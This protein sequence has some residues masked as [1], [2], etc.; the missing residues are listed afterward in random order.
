MQTSSG[1]NKPDTLLTLA[2]ILVVFVAALAVRM[3]QL[4]N[5]PI[6]DELYHLLSAQSW[7][8]DGSFAIADGEYRRAKAFTVLVG[9][10]GAGSNWSVNAIRIL[11]IAIGALL[12]VAVYRWTQLNV[13]WREALVASAFLALLPTAIFLSQHIRFYGL[14]ALLFFMVAWCGWTLLFNGN[15]RSRLFA[16][17]ALLPLVALALHLQVT[18]LVGIAGLI[19]WA[20]L[21]RGD[22]LLRLVPGMRARVAAG[23]ILVAAF[24]LLATFGQD[25]LQ[26]LLETYQESALWNSS[27]NALYY[28]NAYRTDFGVLWALTPVAMIVAFI[29]RPKP[30]LF[31][32]CVFTVAFIF[33]S[34]GGM[35]S[36]RFMF[37]AL[38]FLLIIWSIAAVALAGQLR[39]VVATALSACGFMNG[40][41]RLTSVLPAVAVAGAVGF[42]LITVPVVETSARMVLGVRT[43]PPQYWDRY[44]SNWQAVAPELRALADDAGVLVATQPLHALWY[45]GEI[46][47]AMNATSLA[48][49][50]PPGVRAAVDPRTGRVVFDGIEV[51]QRIVECNASGLVIVHGPALLNDTRVGES[52]PSYLSDRMSRIPQSQRTDMLVY[53]WDTAVPQTNGCEIID[54]AA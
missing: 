39:R 46:D 54:D 7:A 30:A 34:F 6:T 44:R 4:E 53:R 31:C 22:T 9:I 33:Q 23:A 51:L 16:G 47:Y 27:D 1:L 43:S 50:A 36:E 15:P 38:P 11:C 2:G 8:E 3:A 45:L 10:V 29:A 20:V 21:A 19:T 5:E 41:P 18:T 14:H 12:V 28:F 17:A 35:R 37:Y 13:G 49:I 48:D 32:G 42:A 40:M 52:I 24:A 25:R 26:V